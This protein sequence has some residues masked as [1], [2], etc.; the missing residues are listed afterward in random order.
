MISHL[1]VGWRLAAPVDATGW[2]W[3]IALT[4]LLSPPLRF[5][6]VRD[7]DGDREI[8]RRALPL[9]VGHWPVRIMFAF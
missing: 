9:V 7:M 6:D 8:G 1:A 2:T 5:E 4:A 3:I